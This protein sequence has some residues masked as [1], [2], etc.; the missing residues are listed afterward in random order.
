MNRKGK[1][2]LERERYVFGIDVDAIPGAQLA[3]LS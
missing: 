1:H 2:A 3:G